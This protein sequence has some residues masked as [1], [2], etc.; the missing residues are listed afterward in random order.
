MSRFKFSPA[1][2]GVGVAR[3]L[4]SVEIRFCNEEVSLYTDTTMEGNRQ[5]KDDDDYADDVT[6]K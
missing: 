4:G 5:S 2:A 6:N 3:T 1:S